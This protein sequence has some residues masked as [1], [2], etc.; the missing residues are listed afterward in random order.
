MKKTTLYFAL[1]VLL[2]SNV[3]S[4]HDAFL[5]QALEGNTADNAVTIGHGC[6]QA[7]GT[8]RPVI[9]QSVVFPTVA[10]IITATDANG[11]PVAAPAALSDVI[12]QG[13]V[14]GLAN[15]IQS[16][17]IFSLQKE[18][19]DSTGNVIGFYGRT[20]S[21]DIEAQGRVPFAFTSPNFVEGSCVKKLNI[22]VAVADICVTSNPK[23]RAGKVNLWIP[24]NGSTYAVQ[25]NAN[26]VEG[27]GHETPTIQV[28][29]DLVANAFT[30]PEACGAG[31]DVTVTP[32][33]ADINANLG[34][35]G[36]W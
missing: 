22:V 28:S 18:K 30:N 29:R 16:K 3:A 31:I 35:A 14:A 19:V 13:S 4:A 8:I 6:E 17:D 24:D 27:I 20:G 33:A 11:D 10:P 34:I 1:T 15:L 12:Q 32:S 26:G 23:I 21:L 25:G 7:N 2:V 5:S 36:Y 9:A